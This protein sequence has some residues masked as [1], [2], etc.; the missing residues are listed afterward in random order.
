[1]PTKRDYYEILGVKKSASKDELKD[2]YR[3]LALKYHPDRNKE[4]GAEEHF[5]EISE[6]YAVLSDDE[7]RSAYDQYGHAGF[8]QRY[9]QEDIF[10]NAN[11][12]DIFREFGFS[13]G[14]SGSPF[15]DL[16]SSAFFGSPMGGRR[17]GKGADLRYDIHITLEE[18]AKGTAKQLSF[19]R[20]KACPNCSGSGAEPGSKVNACAKCGGN[21]QVRTTRRMG[22]FGSFMSVTTCPSCSGAGKKPDKPCK[23]CLGSGAV[24]AQENFE[25]KI[26]AGVDTG[27]QLRLEGLGERGPTA[28]GDLYVFINVK[29]HPVFKRDGNDIY[30]ETPI[31]F[32]QAALGAEIEVP[33]LLGK[34]KLRIPPGTQ[35]GAS[36]RMQGEGM[37]SV[38]GR[39]KGDQY[40]NVV[41]R[42]PTSLSEKQKKLLSELGDTPKKGF[43]EG[44]FR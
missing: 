31:S 35:T 36:F 41:V 15:D 26:P 13:F 16:F 17:R 39:G 19:R 40:V 38:R 5:K 24:M 21:G 20:S 9:S 11:F 25:V 2:A 34:A 43:F 6:A 30:V 29:E 22:P 27:S 12:D 23:E 4:A 33:V 1:M 42:T 32:S 44:M 28:S 14:G 18:A 3:T 7:K 8:D 10:R 37:P